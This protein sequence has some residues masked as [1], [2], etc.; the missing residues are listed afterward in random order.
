MWLPQAPTLAAVA[1]QG[2]TRLPA[3]PHGAVA[4]GHD[5]GAPWTTAQNPPRRSW[6]R[7]PRRPAQ[8]QGC[9]VSMASS[10]RRTR[11]DLCPA[12]HSVRYLCWSAAH[13][14][15][16]PAPAVSPAL[17]AP[18]E[19]LVPPAL[20]VPPTVLQPALLVASPV[21]LLVLPVVPA[22]HVGSKRTLI[23]NFVCST[24]KDDRARS[25]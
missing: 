13:H 9:I 4:H 5:G 19:L 21:A 15:V 22:S 24:K 7:R 2:G 12:S 14:A 11:R 20:I 16:L 1:V 18:P 23:S 25:A 10:L 3:A 6:G 17:V 8:R